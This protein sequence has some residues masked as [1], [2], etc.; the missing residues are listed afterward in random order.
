MPRAFILDIDYERHQ[1]EREGVHEVFIRL[2][3]KEDKRTLF[4]N[5]I[6]HPYFYF[7][8]N[9]TAELASIPQVRKIS[10][11]EKWIGNEKKKVNKV[12]C[13]DPADVPKLKDIFAEFG[14]CYEYDIPFVRRFMID[15]GV[16]IFSYIEY[17]EISESII[18]ILKCSDGVHKFN[19]MSFD[20]ETYNP[21]GVPIPREDPILML[22]Y[23][24]D[25]TVKAIT[26]KKSENADS[27]LVRNEKEL[28]DRFCKTIRDENVD[29]LFGY[30]SSDFDLPYLLERAKVLGTSLVIGR[31]NSS[32][33]IRKTG[34]FSKVSVVGRVHID[35]YHMVRFLANIGALKTNTYT[36]GEVYMEMLGKS[37]K[38]IRK[39]DIWK[40]WNED[41]T[42]EELIA[43]SLDDAVAT[44]ELG[45]KILPI[46]I[47][48]AKVSAITLDDA[49][50]STTGQLVEAVLLS[51]AHKRGILPPNKPKEAVV[52]ARE[53]EPIEGAY[54]KTPPPGIY[55]KI[56]VFDF[57]S[58]YPSIIVSHNISPETF[59]CNCC[60]NEE[61]YI[62]PEG[63]KFCSKKRGLIP[64]VLS[65][66]LRH[67]AMLKKQLKSLD[68]E[69]TDYAY[70]YARQYAFKIIANSFYGMLRY[71]RARWYCKECAAATTA[72]E[73]YY[74]KDVIRRA[75]EEGFNVLYADT[76]SLF[77]VYEK[78][79]DAIR[80]M[81]GVNKTL[82]KDME[83]ELEDFYTR[84]VF[85]SKKS[86]RVGA[87]KKY[88]LLSK[89]GKIKIRGFELVRRDWSNIA[90]ETQRHILDAVLR[91]G[92]VDKA[93]KIVMEVLKDLREKRVP[94]SK[95]VIY[96]VLRKKPKEYKA[97]GPE[98]SAAIK[99]IQRGIHIDEG[100]MIGYVI[101]SGRGS[102]SDRAE[103]VDFVE[104][105]DYDP[106]YYINN[107]VLPAVEKILGELGFK[108]DILKEGKLQ[109]GLEKWL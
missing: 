98:V 23:A 97:M 27:I 63:H 42:R 16:R 32:F 34:L 47:E 39:N 106:D 82:P 103:L 36:L 3:L 85:V 45:M 10:S 71:V 92:N 99:A 59:N 65:T 11:V 62:S 74:I 26:Y 50:S 102:V 48:I 108:G 83:L 64:D 37:K 88:A 38:E 17:E 41:K 86:E 19:A 6:F 18:K 58:L 107:Q 93:R 87:K 52:D 96:T 25:K 60:S 1:S 24:R 81:N 54:V 7:D 2:A 12:E 55:E 28:I 15:T 9:V 77:V 13:Y 70:A 84:G 14:M 95:L 53:E 21:R 91:E 56:A 94:L 44:Y 109:G 104:E 72:W 90:K 46:F 31:D 43:Y 61:A 69:S 22:S 49:V 100:H 79:E 68:K 80:F 73:R 78:E 75:E 89:S 4:R 105:G 30:N 40:M 76:D 20:I 8:G 5:V 101:R 66:I 67:R 35:V 33:T 57:R 29:I 51:E